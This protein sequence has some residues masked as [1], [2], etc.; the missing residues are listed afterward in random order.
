MK[1]YM[2]HPPHQHHPRIASSALQPLSADPRRPT[3]RE[4][5]AAVLVGAIRVR[6]RGNTA[7]P[8]DVSLFTSRHALRI[9]PSSGIPYRSWASKLQAAGTCSIESKLHFCSPDGIET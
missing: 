5:V 6:V 7:V 3:I 8:G 4:H 9:R 2:I 1:K